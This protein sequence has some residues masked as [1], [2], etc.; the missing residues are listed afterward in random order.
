MNDNN[1]EVK[2]IFKSIKRKNLRQ[3]KRSQ[4]SDGEGVKSQDSFDLEIIQETKE[5]QKLRNRS[6]GVNAYA[7]I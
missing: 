7:K 6:H 2:V 4:S 1:D 5:K 3:R